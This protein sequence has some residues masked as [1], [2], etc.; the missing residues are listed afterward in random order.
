MNTFQRARKL[1]FQVNKVRR[2]P[3][4]QPLKV[5]HEINVILDK[6]QM[7]NTPPNQHPSCVELS[8]FFL[9]VNP[10]FVESVILLFFR[11][12]DNCCNSF[13]PNREDSVSEFSA[14]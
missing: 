7:A 13:S 3:L 10:S 4:H 1:A 6:V 9:R 8:K 11:L 5:L 2:V 14:I 12:F